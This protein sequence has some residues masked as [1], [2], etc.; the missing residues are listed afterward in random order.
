VHPAWILVAVVVTVTALDVLWRTRERRPPHEDIASHLASSLVHS[1][2]FSVTDPLPFL[3]GFRY[4]PPLVYW[5]AD[6]FYAVVGSEAMWVAVL[7]NAVWIATLVFAT[8]GIGSRLWNRRVGVLSVVF[9]V[10]APMLVTSFARLR[11]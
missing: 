8:Y 2:G 7:S 11:K 4:Y 9:V 1:H 5:V 10:T 6:V 3:D